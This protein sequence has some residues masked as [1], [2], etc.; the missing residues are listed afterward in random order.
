M[1]AGR[2]GD[3]ARQR[4]RSWVGARSS[5]ASATRA[6]PRAEQ[7][8]GASAFAWEQGRILRQVSELQR[9]RFLRSMYSFLLR[10][11]HLEFVV[12]W[13]F[14][15]LRL[16]PGFL[17][18]FDEAWGRTGDYVSALL[19]GFLLILVVAS[20]PKESLFSS[21][22]LFSWLPTSPKKDFTT[23]TK[24]EKNDEPSAC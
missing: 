7:R 22:A 10:A 23:K 4:P 8:R 24:R 19:G 1:V 12:S 18:F 3:G 17:Y 5:S 2:L 15:S 20:R 11:L 13:L 21:I 9:L 14:S 6:E 16:L